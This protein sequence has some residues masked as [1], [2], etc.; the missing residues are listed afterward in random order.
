MKKTKIVATIGPSSWPIPV[1]RAMIKNGM[2][3]ARVNG[4]FADT[5]ELKK[6]AELVR[7]TSTEVALILDIKGHE[8][9]LNKFEEDIP[10]KQG[11]QFIIGS[12]PEDNVFPITYPELYKDLR[13][14]SILLIDDGEV[15]LVVTKI[16]NEKIYTKVLSGNFVKKGKSINTPGTKL[17]NPS[18][19]KR[20]IEQ[21]EFC[22]NDRWDYVSA[23]FI[24]NIEDVKYVKKY[25]SKSH[26]KIIAKIE[27]GEGVKNF[28]E[29]LEE[30]EGVMVA[31]GDLGIEVPYEKLPL[32]QKEIIMKAN[33]KG[34]PVITA[35]Q[36]LES[37][38]EKPNPTRA[39]ISDI[40][41]AILD[42]TDA[43]MLSAETSTGKHPVDTIKVMNKVALETE[44]FIK[45]EMIP[46]KPDA[47]EITDSLAKAAFQ[48]C[49]DLDI[50]SIIVVTRTGRAARLLSRFRIKQPIFAFV[51][52]DYFTRR[53]NLS[54]GVYCYKLP[55]KYKDRDHALAGI[56]EIVIKKG[57]VKKNNKILVI[58][59]A[60]KALE[61]D[62]YFPNIFEIVNIADFL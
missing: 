17:S 38:I 59:N 16:L 37:M 52:E 51:S 3:A 5:A 39:E 35:T 56:V 24:R 62:T 27:D 47:P 14:G 4:A 42:G 1:L 61:N 23:S 28:D 50:D 26:M 57:L 31:R 21:I 25:T 55:R 45:P 20:D 60:S 54:S 7:S 22:I 29:I 2:N 34:K 36:M 41:N 12:S 6:V 10:I 9:R 58:G 30:V 43:V 53:I 40:A 15:E 19:T 49:S 44:K 33:A 11:E 48:V 13:I 46:G 32:I 8:V 18:L